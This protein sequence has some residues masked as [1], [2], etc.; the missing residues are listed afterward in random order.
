[1]RVRIA[2]DNLLELVAGGLLITGI[3]IVVGLG[4]ALLAA[5]FVVA[6]L[7]EFSFAGHVWSVR[8]GIPRFGMRS[9]DRQRRKI[10]RQ[11]KRHNP[12]LAEQMRVTDEARR[13]HET[14]GADAEAGYTE[15]RVPR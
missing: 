4:P 11:L 15:V 5:A 7:A 9:T 14:S 8:C 6:L 13:L 3:A 2:V 10:R 1:M 12:E